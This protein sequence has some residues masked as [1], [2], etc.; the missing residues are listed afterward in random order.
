MP[1][2]VTVATVTGESSITQELL[3]SD[4]QPGMVR[5]HLSDVTETLRDHN[6][7]E[8]VTNTFKIL[9]R[10]VAMIAWWQTRV[11]TDVGLACQIC[12]GCVRACSE[13]SGQVSHDVLF[14]VY[15]GIPVYRE[16][17]CRKAMSTI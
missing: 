8:H 6:R 10:L 13:D 7:L 4:S 9:P 3:Q 5:P 14:W 1:H 16:F 11:Q 2:A 17:F 12:Q 15:H